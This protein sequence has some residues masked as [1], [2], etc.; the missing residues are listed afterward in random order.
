MPAICFIL[1]ALVARQYA[2]AIPRPTAPPR[3]L[4]FS[5]AETVNCEKLYI[6]QNLN[7]LALYDPNLRINRSETLSPYIQFK[8][9]VYH[10]R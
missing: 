1:S 10:E 4:P 6:Q 2:A 7:Y 8:S 9:T 5:P 3:K